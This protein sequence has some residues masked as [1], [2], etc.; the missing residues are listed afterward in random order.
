MQLLGGC[1]APR[2]HGHAPVKA[3]DQVQQSF[4]LSRGKALK[5]PLTSLI[6]L[7]KDDERPGF[8]GDA[9]AISSKRAR[10]AFSVDH[11]REAFTSEP[12][13]KRARASEAPTSACEECQSTEQPEDDSATIC[14]ETAVSE[15][16]GNSIG[17]RADAVMIFEGTS[18]QDACEALVPYNRRPR[19]VVQ[20]RGFQNKRPRDQGA[21]LVY[22]LR[23]E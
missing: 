7:D 5:R 20:C 11:L 15:A 22:Q 13:P 12:A 4:A 19:E 10:P 18:V 23:T 1:K 8:I 3:V 16:S 21:L 2:V 14:E 17:C 6:L 9:L